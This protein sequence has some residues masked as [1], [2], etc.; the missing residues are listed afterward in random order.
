MNGTRAGN[1]F[2]AELRDALEQAGWRLTRQRAAVFEHLR[3]VE[4]HP[5]AEEVY[6]AVRRNLPNISL[7]TVYKALEALVDSGLA[8]KLCYSDGPSRYDCRSDAHYHVR[9]LKTGRVRDLHIPYDPKLLEKLDPQLA[10]DLRQQGF[11]VTGYRLEVLGHYND[12]AICPIT[13]S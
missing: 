5:T 10:E 13:S 9:C 12:R 11:E 6:D 1:S 8:S 3:S 4:T 7:A 2:G